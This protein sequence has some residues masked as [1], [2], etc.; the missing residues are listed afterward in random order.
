[1]E[2]AVYQPH[3]ITTLLEPSSSTCF[4]FSFTLLMATTEPNS[5]RIWQ[6][7]LCQTQVHIH[8]IQLKEKRGAQALR[9]ETRFRALVSH[10]DDELAR[11]CAIE[12]NY[13]T[14]VRRKHPKSSSTGR[15]NKYSR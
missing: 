6:M 11:H 12:N 13:N 10:K 5:L 2:E 3:M 8:Y 15:V 1:M 7:R 9:I 14:W 4:L